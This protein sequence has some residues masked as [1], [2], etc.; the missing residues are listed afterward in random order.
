ML[1]T[2]AMRWPCGVPEN[3]WW[4]LRGDAMSTL[5]SAPSPQLCTAAF[6]HN[7]VEIE[8]LR[9]FASPDGASTSTKP[10]HAAS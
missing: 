6:F 1:S 4:S 5:R 9:S 7:L 10:V 8:L 3:C 2:S